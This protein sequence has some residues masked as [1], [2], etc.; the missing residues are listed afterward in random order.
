[1]PAFGECVSDC[2]RSHM[3]GRYTCKF[4]LLLRANHLL[5]ENFKGGGGKGGRQKQK[6]SLFPSFLSYL[7]QHIPHLPPLCANTSCSVYSDT[8]GELRHTAAGPHL[9]LRFLNW[10]FQFEEGRVA[11]GW[12]VVNCAAVGGHQRH[13]GVLRVGFGID[14]RVCGSVT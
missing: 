3:A 1:M 11:A 13:A 6:H 7:L 2:G 9:R 5:W 10:L 4:L 8:T 12:R 14:E